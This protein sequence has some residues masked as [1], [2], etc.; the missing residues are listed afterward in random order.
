MHAFV[1]NLEATALQVHAMA[2]VI[3]AAAA[4]T[5]LMALSTL[6]YEEHMSNIQEHSIMI[7]QSVLPQ[8]Q[9]KSTPNQSRK[10]NMNALRPPMPIL[11]I[12][13]VAMEL[14]ARGMILLVMIQAEMG[15]VMD[16]MA[17]DM[18]E[19]LVVDPQDAYV[20][21]ISHL[22]SSTHLQVSNGHSFFQSRD[23]N[24]QC[25]VHCTNNDNGSTVSEVTSITQT[26]PA[27]PQTMVPSPSPGSM[28]CQMLSNVCANHNQGSTGEISVNGQYYTPMGSWLFNT[29]LQIWELV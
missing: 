15:M 14:V 25:K 23:D 18:R 7:D 3:G 27:P 22:N 16:V 9:T 17:L 20:I 8:P 6:S 24:G 21:C 11:S 4:S 19:I 10:W 28:V 26:T 29:R 12:V 2:R 13:T 1:S 5:A